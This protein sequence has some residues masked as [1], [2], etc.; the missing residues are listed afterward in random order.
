LSAARAAGRQSFTGSGFLRMSP[1][2]HNSL[3]ISG[4][5]RICGQPTSTY[6]NA[7]STTCQPMSTKTGNSVNAMS[8]FCAPMQTEAPSWILELPL[9]WILIPRLARS[10]LSSPFK[11]ESPFV[12][13]P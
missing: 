7:M 4:T 12:R 6:A 10:T 1:L 13:Y 5:V 11:L 8:T 2:P 3:A 9:P